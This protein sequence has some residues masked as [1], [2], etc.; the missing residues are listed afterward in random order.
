MT[1]RLRA[2]IEAVGVENT[3][4]VLLKLLPFEMGGGMLRHVISCDGGCCVMTVA[5]YHRQMDHYR[6]RAVML[7]RARI[8]SAGKLFD[9]AKGS[10]P[11]GRT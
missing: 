9:H 10:T 11:P 3:A 6:P 4:R 1:P 2:A 8:S 5:V 7:E